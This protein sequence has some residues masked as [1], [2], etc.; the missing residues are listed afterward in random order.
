M[1]SDPY[2]LTVDSLLVGST[3]EIDAVARASVDLITTTT[4]DPLTGGTT[5]AVT[6]RTFGGKYPVTSGNFYVDVVGTSGIAERMLVTAGWGAGAGSLTVTRAQQGTA[7]VAHS[8]G[9][10]VAVVVRIQRQEPVDASKQVSFKGR[11]GSFLIPGRA[12]TAG[13]KLIAIH[14][15][16]ASPT[17]VDVHKITADVV[18]TVVKAVTTPPPVFRLYRFT[19]VPTNGTTL[20]KNASD[21]SL[22]S[23]TAVTLWNDASA[24]T[25]AS[26]TALTIASITVGTQTGLVAQELAPRMITAAGYEMSDRVTF[27]ETE[28]EYETLR[29]LEGLCLFANYTNALS[30]PTTDQIVVGLRWIEYTQS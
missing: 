17:L 27:F 3:S 12:G 22:T 16:T 8:I 6:D 24:D 5:L 18:Q 11:G 9:A 1:P 26:A 19:A 30:M 29:P 20:T 10:K 25:V 14:N 28:E 2:P 7:A 13:Q 21:T 23:K 15:A 4:A